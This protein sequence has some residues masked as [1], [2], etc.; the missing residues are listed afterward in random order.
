MLLKVV[1]QYNTPF[2]KTQLFHLR[3]GNKFSNR[4]VVHRV[5]PGL[6]VAISIYEQILLSLSEITKQL[7]DVGAA[8]K[9]KQ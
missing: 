4:W 1:R 8:V 2:E 5:S 9:V 3:P 6:Q 7:L